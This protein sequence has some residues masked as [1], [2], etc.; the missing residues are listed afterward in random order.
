MDKIAVPLQLVHSQAEFPQH[1]VSEKHIL[2][3]RPP[4]VFRHKNAALHILLQFFHKPGSRLCRKSGKFREHPRPSFQSLLKSRDF[5]HPNQN[6]ENPVPFPWILELPRKGCELLPELF[7]P[8]KRCKRGKTEP[9]SRLPGLPLLHGQEH[10]CL[11]Q[12]LLPAHFFAVDL[13]FLPFL[14]DLIEPVSPKTGCVQ[15]SFQI[16]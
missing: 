15:A 3:I 1:F 10:L 6:D 8:G 5:L 14:C 11:V 16:L 4:D 2:D 13:E 12:K 9:Q 7:L